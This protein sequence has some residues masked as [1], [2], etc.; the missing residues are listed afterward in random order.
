MKDIKTTFNETF[1]TEKT[2]I[3]A[4]FQEYAPGKWRPVAFSIFVDVEILPNGL[5]RMHQKNGYGRHDAETAFDVFA[6]LITTP[7]DAIKT[8]RKIP[9]IKKRLKE[10]VG[11]LANV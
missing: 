6:M 4:G 9:E 2:L 3:T 10:I 8:A 11:G 1:T 7:H 5:S